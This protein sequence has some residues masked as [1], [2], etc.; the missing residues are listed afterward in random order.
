V[1]VIRVSGSIRGGATGMN[2]TSRD[3]A[4][5]NSTRVRT[6]QYSPRCRADNQTRQPIS[7]GKCNTA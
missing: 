3:T 2:C 1:S 4:V 6:R 5:N 7:T